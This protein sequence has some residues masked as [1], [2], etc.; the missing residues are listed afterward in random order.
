MTSPSI[1]V[2]DDHE[3]IRDTMARQ[4]AAAGYTTRTA[5]SAES[6]MRLLASEDA[7][8]ALVLSDLRMPGMGGL[9][10]L[11]WLRERL[12]DTDVVMMTAYED[13]ETALAAIKGGAYDFLVKPL[14]LD[15]V[16]HV[17][18]R[19]LRERAMR[20]R[21][22]QL[23]EAAAEPFAMRRLVGKDPQMIA[24]SRT[25]GSLVSNRTPV[26]I[27]G[28]TGT[29]KEVV[30]RTIHFNSPSAD[31]PFV[32]INCTA[33]PEALLESELFGH[34]RGAFTGATGDRKGRFE[35]AGTGTIFL[36]EI[37][38]VSASFQAKLL[39]VLQDGEFY[40]VGA[41]RARRTAAR[42]IAATHRPLEQLV[43]DGAFREDLYFRLRVMEL[44][45]PPLRE[46]RGDIRAIA[47]TLLSRIG[48]EL[49]KPLVLP[50]PVVRTLEKYDWPGNVRELENALTRAAVLARSGVISLQDL[51]LD[52]ESAPTA[53][54][55]GDDVSLEAAMYRHVCAVL[56]R[57]GGN[58]RR[59]A[60][61]L[62]ISRQRLDRILARDVV[63]IRNTDGAETEP[64]AE[65]GAPGEDG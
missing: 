31:E 32:A 9:E 28:E 60:R 26:L 18:A 5:D 61:L 53:S 33:I 56:A 3:A 21:V 50:E 41:E 15:H 17:V 48:R 40:P 10:L 6:A 29:G 25:I 46:R 38:D 43:R 1:L 12:P 54:V 59:T 62:A 57:A 65:D 35:L 52:V 7:E 27:R 58:K 4:L 34:T 30:A 8:P 45:I 20:R 13:M 14:D 42:V 36:D 23:S 44:R 64:F 47:E 16:E 24:L 55:G 39:R 2:V 51:S 22:R 37:G 11:S 49:H 19:C 63:A